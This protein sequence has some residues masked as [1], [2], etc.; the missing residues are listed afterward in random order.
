MSL[1]DLAALGSFISSFA[2]LIS[3]VFVYF[4]LRQVGAQIEQAEKNQRAAMG[5]GR[6]NRMVE[7]ALR[8]AEPG[9]SDALS[10]V[11]TNS[12]ETTPHHLFQYLHYSRALF[13]NA[14]DTFY[15][16]ANGLLEQEPFEGFSR[17]I[18][19]S[20][21]N[22]ATRLMWRAHRAAFGHAFVQFI[23]NVIGNT[24]LDPLVVPEKELENWRSSIAR[25]MARQAAEQRA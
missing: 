8:T 10:H 2:V 4:Q 12:A 9:L 19:V 13:L 21:A 20:L 6:T 25:T 23:D 16:H 1:S 24:P 15:Q 7:L 11:L 17:A 14:E 22:P 18:A 5:Q 3:L